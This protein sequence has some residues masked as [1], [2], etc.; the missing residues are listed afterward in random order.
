MPTFP[1]EAWPSDA[2]VE[3]LDGTTDQETGLPFIA[4]G[5]GPT[6]VPSY[7][8]QFNRRQ[9][10]QN[11][12]LSGW[13]QGMVVDEGGLNIGVYSVEFTL[14][15]ARKSFAG[16]TGVA[17]PDNT[18]KVVYLDGTATLQTAAT[19][20]SDLTTFHCW[21]SAS[22]VRR[23]CG[24]PKCSSTMT[25]VSENSLLVYVDHP[26]WASA[27]A[28]RVARIRPNARE[29]VLQKKR[30]GNPLNLDVRQPID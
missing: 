19:W 25:P 6:S 3:A 5:T 11:A 16:A 12:I 22:R 1:S 4:K 28:D 30:M 7:E 23:S 21:P 14:G 29:R 8:V 17:I 26:W 18:S 20:P 13:R 9:A 10:R 2:T 15:G 24:L 27:A